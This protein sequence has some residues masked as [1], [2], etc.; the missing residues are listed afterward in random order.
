MLSHHTKVVIEVIADPIRQI[1]VQGENTKILDNKNNNFQTDV[2]WPVKHQFENEN[3]SY[4]A[5]YGNWALVNDEYTG[6]NV[7]VPFSGFAGAAMARTDA[8]AFP[9]FAPAGFTRG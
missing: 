4:A 8:Q 2:Y 6:R 7:W 9:W 5:V 3:T 1:F